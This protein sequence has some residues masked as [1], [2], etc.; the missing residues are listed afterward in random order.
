VINWEPDWRNPTQESVINV[1]VNDGGNGKQPLAVLTI[2]I[3]S[4]WKASVLS[5]IFKLIFNN[6]FVRVDIMEGEKDQNMF[7]TENDYTPWLG[8]GR[9]RELER[10]CIIKKG[11]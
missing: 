4:A 1:V 11:E 2:P 10:W 5:S 7:V 6:F 3:R 8:L 9:G